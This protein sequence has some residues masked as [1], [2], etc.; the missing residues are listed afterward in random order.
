M[1]VTN[2]GDIYALA[3]SI[4]QTGP[5]NISEAQFTDFVTRIA[6]AENPQ[7]TDAAAFAKMFADPSLERGA[8]L[9]A[10][11]ERLKFHVDAADEIPSASNRPDVNRDSSV[12]LKELLATIERLRRVGPFRSSGEPDGE[13]EEPEQYGEAYA[14]LLR[15][16]A[17][18][19][20]HEKG[21][22]VAQAFA[23]AAEEHPALRDAAISGIALARDDC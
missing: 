15:H 21:L 6:K 10:A 16:A 1:P 13:P 4:V 17:E 20:R 2:K 22:S 7:L 19:R 8:V 12:A 11:Y 14:E 5:G 18:L 9:R 23:K 3:K